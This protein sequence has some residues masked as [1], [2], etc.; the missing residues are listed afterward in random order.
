MHWPLK[1]QREIA[2]RMFVKAS[3]CARS[4]RSWNGVIV[5]FTFHSNTI[6]E[7]ESD[8]RVVVVLM[9]WRGGGGKRKK[10]VKHELSAL[11]ID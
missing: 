1:V 2:T 3:F 10:G 6:H 9:E 5:S 11:G 8:K 7:S 4:A